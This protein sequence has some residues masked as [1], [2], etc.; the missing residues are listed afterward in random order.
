M[1]ENVPGIKGIDLSSKSEIELKSKLLEAKNMLQIAYAAHLNF[2][3]QNEGSE[4]AE[5][6]EK[7]GKAIGD[8]LIK[9]PEILNQYAT[10]L[11]RGEQDNFDFVT[12]EKRLKLYLPT[13]H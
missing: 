4:F 7:Y 3:G 2:L 10:L 13:M 1:M 9:H 6:V 11:K 12:F 5:F 8:L